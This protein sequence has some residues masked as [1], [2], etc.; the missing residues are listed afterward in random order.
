VTTIQ[1]GR[2]VLI[3]VAAGVVLLGLL[4]GGGAAFLG[5]EEPPEKKPATGQP[6]VPGEGPGQ[7]DEDAFAPEGEI[8]VDQ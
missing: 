3:V 4:V 1:R 5:G 8:G 6:P 2:K 7:V